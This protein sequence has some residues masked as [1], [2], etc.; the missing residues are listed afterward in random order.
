M[1]IE[2]GTLGAQNA[3]TGLNL[4]GFG[5]IPLT[6]GV[7]TTNA[8]KMLT[9]FESSYPG[10]YEMIFTFVNVAG[11]VMVLGTILA[12]RNLA[13][14]GQQKPSSLH[15]ST[16]GVGIALLALPS[17]LASVA[18]TIFGNEANM[19]P[20]SYETAYTRHS[21]FSLSPV[22][23]FVMLI[24]LIATI[25]GFFILRRVAGGSSRGDEGYGKAAT[26]IF[27]GVACIHLQESLQV[28]AK[29]FG[30]NIGHLFS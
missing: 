24:G 27:F 18:A 17:T 12:M 1:S 15:V 10:I 13:M 20:M 22:W 25:R 6:E 26:H 7:T 2:N 14:Q 8:I 30:I 5:G 9:A 4:N 23:H 29:T 28:L 3:D 16:I 19:D 21:G 11:F